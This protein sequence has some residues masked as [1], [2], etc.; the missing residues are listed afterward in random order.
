MCVPTSDRWTDGGVS[1]CSGPDDGRQTAGHYAG[2]YGGV[3]RE[4][5]R[6]AGRW[7]G[8]WRPWEGARRPW[9]GAR[10]G[11]RGDMAHGR[12]GDARRAAARG[13]DSASA[14]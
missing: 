1:G 11:H 12:V 2:R 7:D 6:D 9:E 14:G 5:S 10:C 3:E 13:R 4:V 8:A